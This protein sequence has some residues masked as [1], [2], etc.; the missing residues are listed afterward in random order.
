[1]EN[2]G[3]CHAENRMKNN[4]VIEMRSLLNTGKIKMKVENINKILFL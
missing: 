1:M 3:I 2:S 4:K